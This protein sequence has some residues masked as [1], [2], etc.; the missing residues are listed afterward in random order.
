MRIERRSASAQDLERLKMNMLN[1]LAQQPV[2]SAVLKRAEEIFR[3]DEESDWLLGAVQQA[4]RELDTP[5]AIALI[6]EVLSVRG[7]ADPEYTGWDADSWSELASALLG[8]FQG[9]F[10]EVLEKN[11]EFKKLVEKRRTTM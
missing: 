5:Q 2:F 11:S 9:P 10:D 1:S 4:L 6:G 7:V 3:S 8:Q